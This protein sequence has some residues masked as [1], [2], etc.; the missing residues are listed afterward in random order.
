MQTSPLITLGLLAV[1]VSPTSILFSV[2]TRGLDAAAAL[3]QS[4]PR[5]KDGRALKEKAKVSGKFVSDKAPD[6]TRIYKDL[7]ELTINSSWV[8]IAT[9][10]TNMSRLTPDGYSININ[11]AMLI[12]Y[13][14]KGSLAEGQTVNVLVPGGKV[15]FDGG[16]TAE[17]RTPWFKKMQNGR[18]YLLFLKQSPTKDSFVTT[19]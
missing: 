6:R 2:R 11:Y 17:I 9:P 15:I 8:V 18:S 16:Q 3:P 19:G 4:S 1:L 14:Y 10:Q 12:E 13:A 5:M 7:A